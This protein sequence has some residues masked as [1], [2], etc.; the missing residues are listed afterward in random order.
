[1]V[2]YY[3]YVIMATDTAIIN[4]CRM[5]TNITNLKKEVSDTPYLS[6]NH[7]KAVLNKPV[8]P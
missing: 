1:M 7:R 3:S 4:G 5:K 6:P 8:I 2:H